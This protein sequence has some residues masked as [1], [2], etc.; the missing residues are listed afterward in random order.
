[1]MRVIDQLKKE[2]PRQHSDMLSGLFRMLP[3]IA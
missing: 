1:M 2:K 3:D